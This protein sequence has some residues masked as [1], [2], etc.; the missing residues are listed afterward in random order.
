[1]EYPRLRRLRRR[2]CAGRCLSHSYR[3][4]EKGSKVE[5][6]YF[7]GKRERMTTPE[8]WENWMRILNT[9]RVNST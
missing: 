3:N 2:E 4:S 7:I 9:I 1:M 5:A 6:G 8:R